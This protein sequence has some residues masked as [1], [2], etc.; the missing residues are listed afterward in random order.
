VEHSPLRPADAFAPFLRSLNKAGLKPVIV[1][2]QAVN[3][4]A[5]IFERWDDEHTDIAAIPKLKDLRPF[6]SRDIDLSDV[7]AAELCE[8]PEVVDANLPE[9]G[10]TN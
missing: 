3:I 4:W 10:S 1:A 7:P 2:G 5:S 8:L 6:V 9:S